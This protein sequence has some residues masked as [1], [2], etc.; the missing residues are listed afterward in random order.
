MG[1]RGA[2]VCV[3]IVTRAVIGQAPRLIAVL[4]VAGGLALLPGGS[5][6]GGQPS[7]PAASAAHLLRPESALFYKGSIY[8]TQMGTALSFRGDSA[9]DG[10]IAVV[11]ATG[12][13]LRTLA[14]GLTDPTG[15][16][17][18]GSTLWVN[19]VNQI[20]SFD[21]TTGAAGAARDLSASV[22]ADSFLN[23]LA[24]DR[25]GQLWTT[26]S[27]TSRIHLVRT[28]GSVAT[29]TLPK[30]YA[31]PNGIAVHPTANQVW[32]MTTATG[33]GA[34]L[35]RITPTGYAL[36]RRSSDFAGLDGLV[37]VRRKLAVKTKAGKMRVRLVVEAVFSDSVT[38]KIWKLSGGKL[39]LRATLPGAP[40]DIGYSAALGRL[41]VPLLESGEFTTIKP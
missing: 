26:E 37:F 27:F 41:L 17:V 8:V 15:M 40:A 32:F 18:V 2:R 39:T 12:K 22:A 19:D 1:L 30:E 38:D 4:A 11:D 21:L 25:A 31:F 33:G 24:A 29:F 23:D 14:A 6:A 34:A 9:P 28:D 20:R 5:A 16:A 36:V 3:T 7:S 35:A 10:S 13:V